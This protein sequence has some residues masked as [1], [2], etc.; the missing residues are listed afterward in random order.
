VFHADLF[1]SVPQTTKTLFYVK[2][3]NLP[4]LSRPPPP[5]TALPTELLCKFI[6]KTLFTYIRNLDE[7]LVQALRASFRRFPPFSLETGGLSY[8][9]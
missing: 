7:A 3:G 8:L 1:T 6:G 2:H 5:P 4:R 9:A